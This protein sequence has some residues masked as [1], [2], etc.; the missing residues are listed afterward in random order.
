[1][2]LSSFARHVDMAVMLPTYSTGSLEKMVEGRMVHARWQIVIVL[3][4]TSFEI[5]PNH[6]INAPFIHL[7]G[8][9]LSWAPPK[10]H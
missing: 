1:M 7:W 4:P 6:I 3:A 5:V 9:P 2:T 8:I 10:Q